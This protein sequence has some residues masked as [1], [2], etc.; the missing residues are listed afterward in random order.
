MELKTE[1]GVENW[2]Y[3]YEDADGKKSR[4]SLKGAPLIYPDS[5]FSYYRNEPQSKVKLYPFVKYTN[6]TNY[7][8]G[9]AVEYP[10]AYDNPCSITLASCEF[11][12]TKENVEYRGS[13]YDYCSTFRFVYSA[14]GG[15]WLKVEVLEDGKGWENWDNGLLAD[16]P[17][18]PVDGSNALTVNYY[19]NKKDFKGEFKAYLKGTDE[20]HNAVYTTDGY[21]VLEHNG[22]TFTGCSIPAQTAAFA[23]SRELLLDEG[24]H[25]ATINKIIK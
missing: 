8:Y 22:T 10:I 12:G 3:V 23:G 16:V 14:T 25:G 6:D 2:G 13:T 15:Y 19:Y 20:T 9:E 4:I 1:N 5:R 7:H 21:V 11:K 17:V 18:T 24:A